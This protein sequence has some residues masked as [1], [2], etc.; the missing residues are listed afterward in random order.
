MSENPQQD[1]DMK[2]AALALYYYA[3]ERIKEGKSRAAVID[4]LMQKGI[5]REIAEN[6]L[7]KLDESRTNVTRQYGYRNAVF[8]GVML[9]L[10][11]LPLLG[12]FVPQVTGIVQFIVILLV[13]VGV[14]FLARGIMQIVG[15]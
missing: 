14:F 8:G 10:F 7:D 13:A 9:V 15:L 11:G 2:N 4:D 5:G 6:M 1:T 12:I 3:A